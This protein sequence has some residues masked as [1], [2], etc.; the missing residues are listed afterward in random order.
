MDHSWAVEMGLP[1]I[2]DKPNA[3]FLLFLG[4]TASNNKRAQQKAI[5]F[6]NQLL[7]EWG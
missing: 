6:I 2:A 1:T 7:A 3:E 4:C 5:S